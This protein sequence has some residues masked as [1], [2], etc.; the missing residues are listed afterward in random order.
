VSDLTFIAP[1]PTSV[2]TSDD[3]VQMAAYLAAAETPAVQRALAIAPERRTRVLIESP[4]AGN[5]PTAIGLN[6]LYGHEALRDS[7]L[8]G[9]APMAAHVL[10]AQTFVLDRSDP[11]ERELIAMA[12][13]SWLPLV[14]RVIVYIDRGMT[15]GM[16]AGIRRAKELGVPVEERSLSRWKRG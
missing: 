13:A 9:E 3:D 7:L 14:D 5:S 2:P 10:Y 12:G 15:P 8:R 4:F 1:A 16:E 6:R 11:D